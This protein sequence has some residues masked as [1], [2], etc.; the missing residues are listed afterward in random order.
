MSVELAGAR[1]LVTGASGYIGGELIPALLDAGARV[2]A[3]ARSRLDRRPWAGQVEIMR[4]DASCRE[5]LRRALTGID[6]AYYLLHSMDGGADFG[7]R[8]RAMAELFATE[9]ARAGVR[10]I[11]YLGGMHPAGELSP[12][13]RSRADVGE[14]LLAGDVPAS[15]LQAAVVIGAGSASFDMVRYLTYRLPVVVSPPWVEN[16]LQP[17]AIADVVHY[18]L[19]SAELP[20]EVDRAFDI[21][22]PEVLRYRELLDRFAAVVGLPRRLR[23]PAPT[24]PP[25]GA[26]VAG[27]LV[28]LLAP[29]SPG[30]AAP[31]IE[32]LAHEVIAQENDA[33][34][35]MPSPGGLTG[36]DDALRAAEQASPSD[37]S[38]GHSLLWA[39]CSG[40]ANA[41]NLTGR[42]LGR[43]SRR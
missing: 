6:V 37:T 43:L 4:G 25:G 41:L 9:C 20:P 8:E 38:L 34:D 23:V 31:L 19:A 13:L 17:I 1:V 12:H 16:R 27:H 18:L 40:T 24:P 32:S 39:A 7:A 21:G 35:I 5:D 26:T 22:G 14:V 42:L 2:R 10:R 11:V 30:L 33:V 15:V 28:S 36:L 29:V 3:F